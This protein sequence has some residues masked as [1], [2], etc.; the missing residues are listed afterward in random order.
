MS[1]KLED[2]NDAIRAKKS[3]PTLSVADAGVSPD[4][5]AAANRAFSEAQTAFAAALS[6]RNPPGIL[7]DSTNG[8]QTNSLQAEIA[9]LT[10]TVAQERARFTALQDSLCRSIQD[11]DQVRGELEREVA[12]KE[13][14]QAECA[15]LRAELQST[16]EENEVLKKKVED[17]TGERDSLHAILE[18]RNTELRLTMD[19]L[20]MSTTNREVAMK[21]RDEIV[22]DQQALVKSM[23]DT[24]SA[25]QARYE[26]AQKEVLDEGP[27]LM[28]STS[29]MEKIIFDENS[30]TLPCKER[31]KA[32]SKRPRTEL[33]SDSAEPVASTSKRAHTDNMPSKPPSKK[34]ITTAMRGRNP[35][36]AVANPE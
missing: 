22:E 23:F 24:F 4:F 20:R 17:I 36:N 28:R 21:K 18:T 27:R 8:G 2:Q 11:K 19:G 9:A 29:G 10:A 25:L 30:T 1:V 32:S 3:T 34:K 7:T 26:A 35:I 16:K 15:A 6:A 14:A 33:D 5:Y 12:A 31:T 13:A